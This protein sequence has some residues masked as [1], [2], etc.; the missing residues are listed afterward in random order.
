MTPATGPRPA[1]WTTPAAITARV[2]KRWDSG[3]LLRGRASGEPFEPIAVPLRGPKAADLAEH[4]EEARGWVATL[5]RASKDGRAFR[6][7]TKSVGGR[8]LGRTELP[9]RAM[10]ETFD[11]AIYL[12]GKAPQVQRFDEVLAASSHVPQVWDWV[13]AHPLT[14]LGL[15]EQWPTIL[16]A[17]GWLER[18]RDSAR[19]LREIDEPGVDTKF[20]E[21]H[22]SVL[23]GLLGVRPGEAA[24]AADLGLAHKPTFVRLRF[25]PQVLGFPAGIAEASLRTTELAALRPRIKQ[26]LIIE[27]EVTYLSAPV[28]AGGMVIWGKGFDASTPASLTWLAEVAARGDVLY[29]GDLDT[30]G[31][32]ILNRVRSHLPGVRSVLMDRETL[33]RH[34]ARWG[35]EPS[36]T[37]AY[38]P[39]LD[40]DEAALYEDLVTGRYAPALRLEQERLDWAYAVRRLPPPP[41]CRS[42][43]SAH[44]L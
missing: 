35:S 40:E 16:A 21:G 24:F 22:R 7:H 34:E 19:Y 31:F 37:S 20:V 33:L 41:S 11:Q 39:H 18:N 13:V 12:L 42:R 10:I 15:A 38:L 2:A 6:I 36:P 23:A 9:A 25:D 5:D 14:A 4:L 30:H 44:S 28:P 26:A 32:A 27:N 43:T 1:A 29:W 8:H 17:L 3:A